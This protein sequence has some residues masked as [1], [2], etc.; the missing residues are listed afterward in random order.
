MRRLVA[1]GDELVVD[2]W[3]RAFLAGT[4]STLALISLG[5]GLAVLVTRRS[6]PGADLVAGR[7]GS[8]RSRGRRAMVLG[9]V[10]AM[11]VVVAAVFERP[12]WS[13]LAFYG[14]LMVSVAIRGAYDRHRHR[15]GPQPLPPHAPR[16]S[17]DPVQLQHP[18]PHSTPRPGDPGTRS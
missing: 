1:D 5:G 6:S 8:A 15:D 10:W 12:L 14:A 16:T 4:A 3:L 13:Q 11:V 17:S 18:P 2:P 7:S 9:A